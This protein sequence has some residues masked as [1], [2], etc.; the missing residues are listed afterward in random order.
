MLFIGFFDDGHPDQ[1]EAIPR[2][3]SD[4]HFTSNE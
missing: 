4:L 1:A 2:W 3:S